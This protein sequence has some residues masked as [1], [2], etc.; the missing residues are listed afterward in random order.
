[1]LLQ[2]KMGC[3]SQLPLL[4]LLLSACV[5]QA[6]SDGARNALIYDMVHVILLL[7]LL[8]NTNLDSV[9]LT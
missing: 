2:L 4:L 8:S 9:E 3:L 7:L 1:M 5:M 6:S